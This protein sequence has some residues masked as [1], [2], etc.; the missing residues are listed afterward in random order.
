MRE[1]ENFLCIIVTENIKLDIKGDYAFS[2]RGIR[3]E[4]WSE[5][6][7]NEKGCFSIRG[8]PHEED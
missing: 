8:G 1:A 5:Q 6:Y 2:Q 3:D 7:F 4:W